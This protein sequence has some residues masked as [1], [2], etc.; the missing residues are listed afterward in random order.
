MN[1]LRS[2]ESPQKRQERLST[3]TK[4]MNELRSNESPKKRHERLSL[5]AKSMQNLKSARQHIVPHHDDVINTFLTK[6]RRAAD[7]ICCCCNRLLYESGVLIYKETSYP[8]HLVNKITEFRKKSV[9]NKEWICRNCHVKLKRKK[10]PV[11]AKCNGLAL[12]K[13]PDELSD[14]N[15]LEVRLL[16]RRIPFMKLVSLPRGK[17]A[18]IQGPAVNV[19]TDLDIV[20]EQFPRLPT[21]CQI[22]SLKL[23]RKLEYRK[24]YIHDFVR[25]HKVLLALQWLKSNNPLYSDVKINPNWTEDSN[26]CDPEL[27]QALINEKCDDNNKVFDNEKS[28]DNR[29][30]DITDSTSVNGT[31]KS[32]NDMASDITDSTIIT[33]NSKSANNLAYITKSP[34]VNGIE[35]S[36][37]RVSQNDCNPENIYQNATQRLATRSKDHGFKIH[38]VPGDGDCLFHATSYELKNMTYFMVVQLN[39]DQHW[40]ISWKRTPNAMME[41][42][43]NIFWHH[44]LS[45]AVTWMLTLNHLMM[46][47]LESKL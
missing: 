42:S 44:G 13:V 24:A 27:W 20:C 10:L 38:E 26:A 22:I 3:V 18:G 15:P 36:I 7:F 37:I 45:K 12:S 21:E 25:A 28:P 39:S 29:T 19:P 5:V 35:S 1:N 40:L 34:I 16:S 33:G 43:I 6:I 11:Q 32:I 23:K 14:L 8:L 17:Q 41:L 9:D 46:T 4:K 30:S 31:E 47:I 2:N